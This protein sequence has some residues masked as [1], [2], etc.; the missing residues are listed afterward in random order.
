MSD[1]LEYFC[2][3]FAAEQAY[4]AQSPFH[5]SGHRLVGVLWGSWGLSSQVRVEDQV[6]VISLRVLV[7]WAHIGI[8]VLRNVWLGLHGAALVCASHGRHGAHMHDWELVVELL[9]IGLLQPSLLSVPTS[10][11]EEETV[12]VN[13]LSWRIDCLTLK[14]DKVLRK[15]WEELFLKLVFDLFLTGLTT[16]STTCILWLNVEQGANHFLRLL[17]SECQV[18]IWMKSEDWR[19][20][21][22]WHGI[23]ELHEFDVL[24]CLWNVIIEISD[25]IVEAVSWLEHVFSDPKISIGIE[26]HSVKIIGDLSSILYLTNHVLHCFP[27]VLN[28]E[29]RALSQMLVQ[30]GKRGHHI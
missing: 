4:T 28:V 17:H 16:S 13:S 21:L 1:V 23:D 26:H 2:S 25:G 29:G 9:W 24:R 30:V 20:I 12:D 5:W 22:R 18:S 6:L 19:V 8:L 14:S 10:T 7:N 27:L 15:L 3:V 11:F